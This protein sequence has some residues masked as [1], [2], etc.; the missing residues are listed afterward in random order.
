MCFIKWNK[1]KRQIK[2]WRAPR[3]FSVVFVS[4]DL[5]SPLIE[6]KNWLC[7]FGKGWQGPCYGGQVDDLGSFPLEF[8]AHTGLGLLLTLRLW[9]TS[10]NHKHAN[11][12][13]HTRNEMWASCVIIQSVSTKN[14]PASFILSKYARETHECGIFRTCFVLL[15]EKEPSKFSYFG[16][17]Q[18]ASQ[19]THQHKV[20]TYKY[21]WWHWAHSLTSRWTTPSR[22]PI[23]EEKQFRSLRGNI[24][25]VLKFQPF[26]HAG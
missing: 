24:R 25:I 13:K 19:R 11:T 21:K 26:A 20:R 1:S 3:W 23:C 7:L 8:N 10:K 22:A 12:T 17:Q 6:F 9:W 5:H 14:F 15:H 18:P 2:S 16:K 4:P